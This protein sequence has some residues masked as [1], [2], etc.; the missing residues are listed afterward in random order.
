M[1]IHVGSS[2]RLK[3]LDDVPA[4]KKKKNYVAKG[5]TNVSAE[6]FQL[7]RLKAPEK[8]SSQ[9]LEVMK[10]QGFFTLKKSGPSLGCQM[11]P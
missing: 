10:F 5:S 3:V 7:K 6:G 8:G 2:K 1:K 11:V 9:K 4:K